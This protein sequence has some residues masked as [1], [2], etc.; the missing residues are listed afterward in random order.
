MRRTFIVE[1]HVGHKAAG[2]P[3]GRLDIDDEALTVRCIPLPWFAPCTAQRSD[4]QEITVGWAFNIPRMRFGGSGLG[5]KK[6]AVFM[7]YKSRQIL[8]EL[9]QRGYPV[10][11]QRKGQRPWP[12]LPSRHLG[13]RLSRQVRRA[14]RRQRRPGTPP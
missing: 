10:I 7:P 11:D 14:A 12:L 4:I 9:R 13:V 1:L 5:H 2:Y 8:D 6:V 3:W